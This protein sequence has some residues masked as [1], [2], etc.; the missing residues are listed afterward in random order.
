M[1]LDPLLLLGGGE[2]GVSV[3]AQAE[4]ADVQGL[5]G[6]HLLV[7]S[8]ALVCVEAPV[9]VE[10]HWGWLGAHGDVGGS[11]RGAG[12]GGVGVNLTALGAAVGARQSPAPR[13]LPA[14]PGA[15]AKAPGSGAGSRHAALLHPRP[16]HPPCALCRC[17][18]LPWTRSAP[19][20][21]LFLPG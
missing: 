20:Q 18:A 19:A 2:L 4:L 7:Q 16:G 14:P 13:A 17:H 15:R 8:R 11:G 6:V 1:V 3:V 10:I 12:D 21:S 5:L 9:E